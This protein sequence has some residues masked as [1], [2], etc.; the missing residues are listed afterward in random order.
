MT[1]GGGEHRE[2]RRAGARTLLCGAACAGIAL[3]GCV[4]VA[5]ATPDS[6][7]PPERPVLAGV[8]EGGGNGN[9]LVDPPGSVAVQEPLPG[10]L[11][12]SWPACPDG[13]D[14]LATGEVRTS[15]LLA[16]DVTLHCDDGF[17]FVG[18]ASFQADALHL[19]VALYRQVAFVTSWYGDASFDGV[20]GPPGS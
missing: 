11:T 15:D 8:Y 4:E 12:F 3:A 16:A 10:I 6:A 18:A 20:R 5:P 2:A 13:T 14:R 7:P 19:T 1:A 9:D 17:Y